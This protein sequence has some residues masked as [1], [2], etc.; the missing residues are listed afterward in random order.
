MQEIRTYRAPTKQMVQ[1]LTLYTG[2]G[3]P[4]KVYIIVVAQYYNTLR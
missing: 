3:A 1:L 2:N 4:V